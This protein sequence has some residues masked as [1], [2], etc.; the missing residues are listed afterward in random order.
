MTS[1]TVPTSLDRPSPALATAY[2]VGAI[3]SVVGSI[4]FISTNG[5]EPREAYLAPASVVGCALA[6]L[7]CLILTLTLT[8]WRT[9]L[10]RWAV[11][12]TAAGI[13]LA[14]SFALMQCTLVVA[15]AKKTDNA[16]F[17][18]LFFD[19]PW[20][21]GAMASKSVLCLVGLLAL[22]VSGWR[23]RSVPRPAAGLLGLAAV[24][25]IWPPFPPGLILF[26]VAAFLIARSGVSA[27]S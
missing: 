26:S 2:S 21:L 18:D 27:K 22:A 11:M 1:T 16:L 19:S 5:M 3:L 9:T 7:G 25:S 6:G 4:G 14:G 17:D 20:T 10:P 13:W 15:A 23:R 8:Q 24:V 12:T